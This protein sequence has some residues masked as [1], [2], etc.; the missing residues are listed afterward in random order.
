M[1][2]IAPFLQDGFMAF[3]FKQFYVDDKNCGMP[4]STDAVILGAWAKLADAKTVLD[5]GAGCGLLTLMAAQRNKDAKITAVEIDSDAVAISKINATQSPWNNRI[6]IIEQNIL[7][8]AEIQT[9]KFDHIIC[10]PPYFETGPRASNN[11]RAKARHVNT[12]DFA[13]L[14]KAIDHLLTHEGKA[15]LILPAQSLVSFEKN[16]Q[17][18]QNL[19]LTQICEVMSVA[20]KSAKRLLLQLGRCQNSDLTSIQRSSLVIRKTNLQ[21]TEQMIELTKAFYL[22][23]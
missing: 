13:S 18:V 3:T 17:L 8:F 20:G 11:A 5:I 19:Q 10:N 12:L 6:K 1:G 14:L 4:V 22:N 16:I 23:L 9:D 21:Y 7:L 15:S 2:T